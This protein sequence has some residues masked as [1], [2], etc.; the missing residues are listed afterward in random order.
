MSEYFII[1]VN[2]FLD[3]LADFCAIAVFLAMVA[4][5]AAVIGKLL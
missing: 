3:G 5:W 1:R 2:N 4:L